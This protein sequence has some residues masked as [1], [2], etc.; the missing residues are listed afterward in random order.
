MGFILKVNDFAYQNILHFSN[1]S[2]AKVSQYENFFHIL[3]LRSTHAKVSFVFF[4][5]QVLILWI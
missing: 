5:Y 4:I 2:R 1:G 3:L